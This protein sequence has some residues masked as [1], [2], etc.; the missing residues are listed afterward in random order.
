MKEFDFLFDIV[1]K[2]F[3]I[4]LDIYSRDFDVEYK[5]PSDPVTLAD[6]LVDELYIRE[7]SRSFPD[8]AFLTEET[9]KPGM[10]TGHSFWCIDP[11]DGTKDY[12]QK[13]GEFCTMVSYIH[14][15]DIMFGIIGLPVKNQIIFSKKGKGS[16]ILNNGIRERIKLKPKD[17][18]SADLTAI[19]SRNHQDKMLFSVLDHLNIKNR[20]VRGS[21]GNKIASILL[22]EADIYIHPSPHTKWW[23]SS[24]G[25][26]IIREAGG[27]F[28][29]VL[30][31]R[32]DYTGKTV[33][34]EKGIA[35]SNLKDHKFLESIRGMFRTAH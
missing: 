29:D 5:A 19:H 10:D 9:Y 27:C 34:N 15:G 20:I 24:A 31:N 17:I 4:I 33:F 18:N 3:D 8:S 11:L 25:E 35:A 22:G 2:A 13:N 16:Y 7:I 32:I 23:D 14:R 28:T 6:K 21:V 12:I 30:N 1:K 26:I